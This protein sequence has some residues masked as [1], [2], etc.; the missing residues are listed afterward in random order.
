MT[1]GTDTANQ[2]MD[3]AQALIQSRGFNAFSYKDLA[4]VVGIRTA[5]IHY[6]FPSKADLGLAVVERYR[7]ELEAAL[8]DIDA[9]G[10]SVRAQLEAFVALYG[11]TETDGVI[12]VC[13]SL[14][15]DCETLPT[16]MRDAVAAYL[17]RSAQWVAARVADGV[18]RGE[19]HTRQDPHEL[20]TTLVS[21]LQGGLIL[22]RVRA[23]S[24]WVATVA[25]VFF[26]ALAAPSPA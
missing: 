25:R 14:A 24:P 13:G 26:D 16:P 6:H 20:A 4:A 7:A 11:K 18:A 22:A 10:G 21:G 2:L 8:A 15:T 1:S 12:C 9:R 19:L 23:G 5:S 3:E 17:D